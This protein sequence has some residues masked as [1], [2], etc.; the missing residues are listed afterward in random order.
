MARDAHL[1]RQEVSHESGNS[2]NLAAKFLRLLPGKNSFP[3]VTS[4]FKIHS[5]LHISDTGIIFRSHILEKKLVIW[6][7][8]CNL[9]K[10]S[11][12]MSGFRT[13]DGDTSWQ[14]IPTTRV[15]EHL[16]EQSPTN[17]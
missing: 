1:A 5:L 4:Q 14:T 16:T 11:L 3:V 12:S 7:Q 2:H 9:E 17:A 10:T 6:R 13:P 8:K 15:F